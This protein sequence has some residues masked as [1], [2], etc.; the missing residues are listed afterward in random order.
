MVALERTVEFTAIEQNVAEQTLIEEPAALGHQPARDLL[1]GC[2]LVHAVQHV[3][4]KQQGRG[5]LGFAFVDAR[6]ALFGELVEAGVG[7]DACLGHEQEPEPLQVRD[8]IVGLGNLRVG[9]G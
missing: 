9:G 3:T 2:E 7:G 4:A 5:V 8:R 1:G 6:R